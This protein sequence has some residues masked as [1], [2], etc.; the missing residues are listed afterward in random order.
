MAFA[1]STTPATATST[2]MT[3]CG[4]IRMTSAGTMVVV[5]LPVAPTATATT[6]TAGALASLIGNSEHCPAAKFVQRVLHSHRLAE[7]HIDPA[8]PQRL[9][10]LPIDP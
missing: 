5:I 2:G 8:L 10:Y 3:T 7:E 6:T 1:V 9:E 4:G